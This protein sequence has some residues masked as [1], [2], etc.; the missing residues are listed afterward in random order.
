MSNIDK[1]IDKMFHYLGYTSHHVSE[2]T[3]KAVFVALK[4][5]ETTL[6]DKQTTTSEGDLLALEALEKLFLWVDYPTISGGE[7]LKETIRQALTRP[8]KD[9]VD[10]AGLK[11]TVVANFYHPE[12]CTGGLNT[13]DKV[14]IC[15]TISHLSEQGH[16]STPKKLD[17]SGLRKVIT[18]ADYYGND[19]LN[20]KA[21]KDA[22]NQCL[23][24]VERLQGGE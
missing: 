5:I 17:L 19:Y 11:E 9:I 4:T 16:L 8:T 22:Y 10:V 14:I 1:A 21:D 3:Q 7:D 12:F 6:R 20:I 2:E 13:N 24:D 15:M 23:D 18:D